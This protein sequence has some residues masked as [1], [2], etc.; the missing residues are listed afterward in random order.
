MRELPVAAD[1]LPDPR[2]F[3]PLR[4]RPVRRVDL[5]Q[6]RVHDERRIRSERAHDGRGHGD[7]R[8]D[9]RRAGGEVEVE[10]VKRQP[11]NQ[12]PLAFGFE[13]GDI[14]GAQRGIS[15]PL[16]GKDRVEEFL[17]QSE[18][19]GFEGH[20]WKLLRRSD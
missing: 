17:I 1:L 10:L 16:A 11:V 4:H 20:R 13:A 6:A 5:H 3:G 8:L 18:E 7:L 19:F 9:L 15:F 2:L 12:M 14:V